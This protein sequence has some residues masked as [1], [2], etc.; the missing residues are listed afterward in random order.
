MKPLEMGDAD[1][2]RARKQRIKFQGVSRDGEF[3]WA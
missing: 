2:V 1:G 3:V